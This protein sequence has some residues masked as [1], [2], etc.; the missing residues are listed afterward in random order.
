[1]VVSQEFAPAVNGGQAAKPKGV[2]SL[3]VLAFAARGV[4]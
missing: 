2:E 1:M 4:L 3:L